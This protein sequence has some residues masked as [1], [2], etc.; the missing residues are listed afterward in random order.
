MKKNPQSILQELKLEIFSASLKDTFRIKPTDFTRIR[1]QSF[2]ETLLFLMT[3]ITK[4][5]SI[6]IDSFVAELNRIKCMDKIETFTKSAFVQYRQK[7][8][9][10]VFKHLS[11]RFVE[12]FYSDNDDNIKLW[13]GFRLLAVDGS[14]LTLPQTK[15]LKEHFGLTKNKTE[16]PVVQGRISTLYDVLNCIVIDSTLAPLSQ[17]EKQLAIN[18]LES[19][20]EGD[21]ILYDRGYPSFEL[22]Y[23][24]DKRNID[25][26]F[27]VHTHFNKQVEAFIASEKTTQIV[28]I[29]PPQHRN[30]DDKEYTRHNFINA[31][32]S[33]VVLPDNTVEVLIS[34]LIKEQEYKDE[35]FKDL[36][37]KRWKVELFY[38][39]LKNKLLLAN[40]SGYTIQAIF[41][42]FYSS[43]FVSNIQSLLVKEIN[44]ELENSK[45]RTKYQYKVNAN[46][47]Y[48]ILKNRILDIFLSN[49]PMDAITDEI[50]SLL[51]RHTIPIRLGR[52]IPRTKDKYKRRKKPVVTKNHKDAL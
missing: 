24:H 2:Q 11:H 37:F 26:L 20:V 43:I 5:L 40:F 45:G 42:D 4:T 18:H 32:L 25:F 22:M 44:E 35:I 10:N 15:D 30:L 3:R 19:A 12:E 36:Y 14:S 23:E 51:K 29:Y 7:I 31:R 34:S 47:S 46:L 8:D 41:Q 33:R 9:A 49:K 1:K 50:S 52:N 39:E 21:L 48:G 16:T 13:Q 17:S 38:D 28:K 6:E 27:R